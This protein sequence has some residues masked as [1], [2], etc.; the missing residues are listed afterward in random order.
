M[1]HTTGDGHS[2]TWFHSHPICT[3]DKIPPF[4]ATVHKPNK[5]KKNKKK[6]REDNH[7]TNFLPA[8]SILSAAL[9]INLLTTSH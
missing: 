8:T 2:T 1:T 6:I 5:K 9:P 7:F 4:N 3:I